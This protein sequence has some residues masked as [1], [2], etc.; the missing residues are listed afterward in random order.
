MNVSDTL[1]HIDTLKAAASDNYRAL[2]DSESRL[3]GW[4]EQCRVILVGAL[5]STH[6]LVK[7]WDYQSQIRQENYTVDGSYGRRTMA[8]WRSDALQRALQVL[9]AV[10]FAIESVPTEGDAIGAAT[11]DSELWE[12]VGG[13]VT[14]GAWDKVPAS[15]AIFVE[16]TVRRWAGDPRGRD[17]GVRVGKDLYATAFA[18]DGPLRLG[19]QASEYE[20][21]R[22]LAMGLALAVGN[23]D[24]HRIQRRAD[25]RPYAMGVLGLGS[26][27]LTQ[28][29]REHPD[30]VLG[31]EALSEGGEKD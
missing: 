28:V 27:L 2:S 11:V 31:A 9:D 12:H 26:L 1:G 6:R 24:R 7:V 25:Q 8:A 5:G 21:W 15:V 19:S 14:D 20:G 13:L 29:R 22:S 3:L 10:R 23:V 4:T 16:D 30:R 18:P 17:G